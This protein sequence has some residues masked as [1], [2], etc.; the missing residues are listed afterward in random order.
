M[1]VSLIQSLN[2]KIILPVAVSF[3]TSSDDAIQYSKDHA[4]K[5]R[6]LHHSDFGI[7]K[8]IFGFPTD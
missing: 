5:V 3:F 8:F 6:L 7:L 1:F 2:D 4:E